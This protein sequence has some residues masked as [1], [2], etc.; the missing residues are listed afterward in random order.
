MELPAFWVVSFSRGMAGQSAH[1]RSPYPS[2]DQVSDCG[3]SDVNCGRR[4]GMDLDRPFFQTILGETSALRLRLVDG[5][6]ALACLRD[7]LFRGLVLP[8]IAAVLQIV[9]PGVAR[10]P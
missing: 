6:S 2:L 9:R 5:Q 3:I 4:I 7:F 8:R 1:V 10:V